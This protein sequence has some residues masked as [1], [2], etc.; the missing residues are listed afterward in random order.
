FKIEGAGIPRKG[1]A[2]LAGE[3]PVGAVTSGTFSP[4]LEVGI[5]MAYLRTDLAEPGTEV[6]IDVRGKRRP[7]RIASKPLYSKE[8]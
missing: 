2:V 1:N 8:K 3:E 5:G 7:A 4:S 6:E